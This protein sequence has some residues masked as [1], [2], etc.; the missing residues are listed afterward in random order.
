MTALS[1]LVAG[2]VAG[3][4]ASVWMPYLPARTGLGLSLV[5]ASL[6][7]AFVGGFVLRAILPRLADVCVS[8]PWAVVAIGL[9][10][11]AGNAATVVAQTIT[12]RHVPVAVAPLV[13]ANPLF[14][15]GGA[16]LRLLVSYRVIVFAGRAAALGSYAP[17]ARPRAPVV[18][19]SD[20]L[21]ADLVRTQSAV[22]QTC[23]EV[24]RSAADEIPGRVVDAL[25]E[26]GTCAHL[27]RQ[28]TPPE[29]ET[30]AAVAQLLDGLERFQD[31]L[32]DIARDA[33]AP[34]MRPRYELDHADGLATIRD[35]FERLRSLGVLR[36][37]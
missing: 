27:L 24:S 31:A 4:F 15:L 14:V 13:S 8:Y 21:E 17:V 25:A 30:R 18:R 20:G 12:A 32:T 2:S 6:V 28:A 37:E 11:F 19:G 36:D 29:P 5:Y 16:A 26:L 23:I 35:S 3:L 1:L 7:G 22:A 33:A 9:G 10:S 34:G